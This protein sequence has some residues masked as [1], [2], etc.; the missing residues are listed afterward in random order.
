MYSAQSDVVISK[1][2]SIN[3]NGWISDMLGGVS[4]FPLLDTRE[5]TFLC[6]VQSRE[7]S[8][9]R[10]KIFYKVVFNSKCLLAISQQSPSAANNEKLKGGSS[11]GDY[12]WNAFGDQPLEDK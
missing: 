3:Q 7:I 6:F 4:S 2:A 11:Q 1:V 10:F 5:Q 8:T 9:D 12:N